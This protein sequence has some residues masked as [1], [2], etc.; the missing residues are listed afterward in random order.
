MS[1]TM[2]LSLFRESEGG[3]TTLVPE[4]VRNGPKHGVPE[5]RYVDRVRCFEPK[6]RNSELSE[7]LRGLVS[8][9][10]TGSVIPST[11]QYKVMP[12][13]QYQSWIGLLTLH[14]KIQSGIGSTPQDPVRDS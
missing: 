3:V 2:V 4:T 13:I 7:V 10:I 5:S 6:P 11:D 12:P 9:C 8:A 1:G 14:P